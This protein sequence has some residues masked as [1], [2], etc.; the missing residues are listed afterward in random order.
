MSSETSL[1]L[2]LDPPIQ[3]L[4][5]ATFELLRIQYWFDALLIIDESLISDLFA[6]R[7]SALCDEFRRKYE[8]HQKSVD[9][10]SRRN[11]V[12]NY[13]QT[14]RSYFVTKKRRQRES[15]EKLQT[16]YDAFTWMNLQRSAIKKS[17]FL[18]DTLRAHEE[19]NDEMDSTEF[20]DYNDINLPISRKENNVVVEEDKNDDENRKRKHISGQELRNIKAGL[21]MSI[22]KSL[23]I[24]RLSSTLNQKEVC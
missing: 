17:K 3:T 4:A 15:N 2:N 19:E 10:K 9:Q 12:Y 6:R 7:L 11:S 23:M 1:H 14:E 22:W 20:L 16:D 8:R 18:V 13:H 5:D 24:I 21:L